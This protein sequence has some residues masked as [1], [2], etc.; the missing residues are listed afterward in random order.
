M[1][2]TVPRPYHAENPLYCSHLCLFPPSSWPSLSV[3]DVESNVVPANETSGYSWWKS[4]LYGRFAAPTM[5]AHYHTLLQRLRTH[6]PPSGCCLDIGCGSGELVVALASHRP[7]LDIV[8]IDPSASALRR[9][10]QRSTNGRLRFMQAAAE[11]L[12]FAN[13]SFD[14]ITTT[15]VMKHCSSM[16]RAFDEMHR[17]LRPGGELHIFEIDPAATTTD[18]YSGLVTA[19]PRIAERV[20]NR[21]ILPSSIG[22]EHIRTLAPAHGWH[23]ASDVIVADLP[24]YEFTLRHAAPAALTPGELLGTHEA[25]SVHRPV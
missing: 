6:L 14:T 5:A 23:I 1:V 4:W 20:L 12:P 21:W 22:A 19:F 2:G 16:E 18:R 9:A 11:S 10:R 8:G 15:G 17:V 25:R 7:D 3:T 24:L 13:N